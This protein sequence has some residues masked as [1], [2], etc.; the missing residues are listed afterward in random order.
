MTPFEAMYS[1]PPPTISAYLPN[2]AAVNAVDLALRAR[3]R[4]LYHLKHNLQAAQNRMK[5][6]TDAHRTERRF[7]VG[8]RVFLRLQPYRQSTASTRSYSKLSPRFYGPFRVLEK[9]DDVAYKLDLPPHYRI[10]PVF[11]VS[12]LKLKLG[13]NVTAADTAYNCRPL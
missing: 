6:Y 9:I 2:S 8:D 5:H 12:S 3:D 10:H 7:V 13:A 4:T 1:R 11:H